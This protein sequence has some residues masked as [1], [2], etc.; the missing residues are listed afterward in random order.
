MGPTAFVQAMGT[1]GTVY[2]GLA[3]NG[4]QTRLYAANT[5]LGRIDVFD[6]SFNPVSLASGAFVDPSLP[7]RLVPFNVQAT[8]RTTA[9][10]RPRRSSGLRAGWRSR[11][12]EPRCRSPRAHMTSSCRRYPK[13]SP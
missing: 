7:T 3:I 13:V 8:I 12:L 4:A 11:R 6:S 2:T 1:V 10:R 9:G 5:S